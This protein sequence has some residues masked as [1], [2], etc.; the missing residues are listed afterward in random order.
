MRVP[1][2]ATVAPSP[3]KR[4]AGPQV[5]LPR[6]LLLPLWAALT[7]AAYYLLLFTQWGNRYHG[8][9]PV[10]ALVTDAAIVFAAFSS[11]EVLRTEKKVPLRAVA[12]AVGLPL[13]LVALLTLWFGL[14]RHGLA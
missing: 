1:K 6:R 3:H 2:A 4:G 9:S 11:L 7:L 5:R 8:G 14:Q 10:K 12:A 13:A